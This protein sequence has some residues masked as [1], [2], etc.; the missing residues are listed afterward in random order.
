MAAHPDLKRFQREV[1]ALRVK[2]AWSEHCARV[3][4]SVHTRLE[5][6]LYDATIP[7]IVKPPVRKR[8]KR[9]SLPRHQPRDYSG[10][11]LST[12]CCVDKSAFR[13]ICNNDAMKT[14]A[15]RVKNT[16]TNTD[17]I[18]VYTG[19]VDITHDMEGNLFPVPLTLTTPSVRTTRPRKDVNEEARKYTGSVLFEMYIRVVSY[20]RRGLLWSP[21]YPGAEIDTDLACNPTETV[22]PRKAEGIYERVSSMHT[23]VTD[24]IREWCVRSGTEFIDIGIVYDTSNSSSSHH[25]SSEDE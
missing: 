23:Y 10:L 13:L 2:D 15:F 25:V 18:T 12:G 5:S 19:T 8:L 16:R 20:M 11:E 22:V 6:E 1:W 7:D 4:Y 24:I 9:T 17:Q 14:G 3:P 21:P